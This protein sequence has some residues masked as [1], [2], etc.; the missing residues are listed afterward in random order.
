MNQP[1]SSIRVVRN[2]SDHRYEI[3]S[4]ETLAGVSQYRE[5]SE[6]IIFTHTKVDDSFSGEGLGSRLAHDALEDARDRGKLIV[7]VCPF[8]AS[9]IRD[10]LEFEPDVR[11]PDTGEADGSEE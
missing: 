1:A 8:I 5:A 4:D 6:Q 3:W 10:H 11:W 9:Y 2:D 7:P